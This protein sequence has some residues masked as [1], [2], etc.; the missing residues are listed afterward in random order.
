MENKENP[1]RAEKRKKLHD[2][3][4]KSVDPFPHNFTQK[5][6]SQKL[7]EQF[8]HLEAGEKKE[9]EIVTVAGR[10]MTKRDMGKASFF[11]IQDEKGRLQIYIRKQELEEKSKTAFELLDIGDIVGVTGFIFKTKKGELSVHAQD[12]S[13]LCKTLEPLPEKFHGLTDV[14]LKYR[15]R[16]LD[17]I[18]NPESRQVFEKRSQII[19]ELRRFLDE[20][21]FLEV[22]TPVLQPIYG[23]AAAYP[24]STHHRA[25]DM[26]LFL[27]ISPE[28]YLKRLIV[29]GFNKVYEIGKNFR[30]EGIDRSHNPEFAMLEYYEAY[31]DYEYQMKQFEE[32]VA[33]VAKAVTGSTK[34][35]Y[36][37]KELDFTP[38][39]R[40]LT[41]HEGIKEYGGFDPTEMNDQELFDKLKSLGSDLKKPKSHGEMTMEAFELTVE[42]H[43]WQ[44]TFIVDFPKE[45]SPLTKSHRTKPGLVE[46]FEPMAACMEIGN[47]YTELNDP[48]DQRERLSEQEA[49]RVIDEEAQP[50]D[51][52]FLHAIDVGMPPTG[53]VGLGVERIVMLLTDQPSIRDIIFFPTMKHK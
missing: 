26:K 1:L 18:M 7:K 30:N 12:F 2:L 40:R 51:E 46:R 29:G 19:R 35:T 28:L 13:I 36:Q 8:G 45:V 34:V 11:N 53:G 39:W 4:E 15:Y 37:E 17:L 22:E 33:H 3:K 32:M 24:F 14:E 10:V 16:H 5:H 31:T 27:K 52:D 42:E 50:M 48:E 20:R 6:F 44:P 49:K 9:Q 25:L 38:P 41:V 47:A 21:G 23:G 43:L